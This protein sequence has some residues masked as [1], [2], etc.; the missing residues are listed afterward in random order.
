MSRYRRKRGIK[1]PREIA[2]WLRGFGFILLGVVLLVVAILSSW[3]PRIGWLL[4]VVI[5]LI[6]GYYILEGAKE[7]GVEL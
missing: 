7:L 5:G 2:R 3:V 4:L 6:A 1:L